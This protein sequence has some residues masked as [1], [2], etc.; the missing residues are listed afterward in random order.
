MTI[1]ELIDKLEDFGNQEDTQVV[2][3]NDDDR[4]GSP[5]GEI[6]EVEGRTISGQFAVV[7]WVS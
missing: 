4:E 2:E 7:L 6:R 1:K 3:M 5:I